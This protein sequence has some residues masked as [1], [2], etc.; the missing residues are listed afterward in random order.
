MTLTSA[1]AIASCALLLVSCATA[2]GGTGAASSRFEFALIGDVPYDGRQEKQFPNV[3]NEINAA[4]LAFVI[5]DGDFQWDGA[6][7][8]EK[9][10]GMTPCSD[11]TFDD[12]L[13]L[14]QSF[15]HPFIFTPGDNDWTDCHRSKPRAYD[16][17]E[18]LAKVRQ[19]FFQGD[20]S[21]GQRTIRLTRQSEN[22]TYAK[23]RENARWTHGD[24]LFVTLHLVGSNNNLGRTPEMDAE[25]AERTAA[26]IA[27]MRQAFGEAKRS[28]ARGIMIIAQAN[29]GFENTWPAALQRAYMLGG[30]GMKPPEKRRATGFDDFLEALEEETL[31]FGKPVVYVHGDTHHFR[32]DKPLVGSVSRRVIENFSRVETFGYPNTHWVRVIVDPVDPNVFSFRQ[33]I[34]KENL[35]TH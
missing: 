1:L 14:A 7:W 18:R 12:R 30:L 31:A 24:A 19:M 20:H 13:R 35:V 16:P 8:N 11:A 26:S 33:Q 28:G 21:L 22:P 17:L 34:V 3:M 23:F 27:W 10:G 6:G 4:D 2:P 9:A 15:R 25:H 29:P 32:V 5:H